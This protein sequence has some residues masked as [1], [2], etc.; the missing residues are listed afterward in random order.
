M[1]ILIEGYP[2]PYETVKDLV[3]LDDVWG[4][5]EKNV[6]MPYVG[7]F[8]NPRL[9]DC[10]F[11]LPKVLL[12]TNDLVFGKY[13]PE[14]II[15]FRE[16]GTFKDSEESK[17]KDE[18]QLIYTL[19]V[20]IYR[21]IVV[22]K[23]D[24]NNDTSIVFEEKV[25]QVG[26][27][28]RKQSDTF[29]DI[30]L[31]LLQFNRDN[32]D[33]FMFILK[34]LHSGFNKIN[35]T[36]TISKSQA[37]VQSKGCCGRQDVSYLNPVN[38]KRTINFDEELLVIFFSI[39]H[40]LHE[41]YGFPVTI[42]ENFD[43]ITGKQFDRYLH[44]M[45][46]R[47]LRQIKYKY[48]SDKA[49]QL[50]EL[51]YAF[52]DQ[53]RQIFVNTDKTEFLLVKNFNIVF[54]AIIDALIGD[55]PLPDGMDK[56]QRDG[57]IVDHLYTAKSLIENQGKT[58]YIG[59]SKY[60]K[61][62]GDVGDTSVYKQYT[63]A[64]NVIQWNLDIFNGKNDKVK[65]SEVKLRDEETEGYN[66]IPNFFI[67]A[68]LD[69]SYRYNVDGICE[70]E[71]TTT[72]HKMYQFENRLFD[73][74]TMLL[75][76]Y[77]VNFLYVLSM[78]GKNNRQEIQ[79]WKGEV[80][81]KFRK[82]IQK[83]LQEDFTFYALQA[84]EGVDTK[85]YIHSHFKEVIGKV[86]APFSN[87]SI[88]SLALDKEST[89]DNEELLAEL[90]K[91]FFVHECSLGENPEPKIAEARATAKGIAGN[92]EKGGVLMVM[93]ENFATKSAV[94]LADGRIAVGIKYS[95][96]SMEI[97]EHLQTIGF[98][99]FHHRNDNDQHLF[100]VKSECKVIG[101]E[102]LGDYYANV[103]TT[104]MYVSV[105]LGE[106]LD[107]SKVKCS[108]KAYIPNTRYDAQYASVESLSKE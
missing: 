81:E 25:A 18:E 79:R 102:E 28:K 16:N 73:R 3:P 83:W 2:Y 24:A 31:A 98:V 42:N 85:E 100:S 33:F 104:E 36:R 38:K 45:G 43:L 6:L 71:K 35:W 67:S 107:A 54:E 51:C 75:F 5:V 86:Y 14:A 78:Y 90:R 23:N 84:H 39:L 94:F 108:K 76:H 40:H 12:D 66:V 10:V 11:V 64:R 53:T 9:A 22:F 80:R 101:K 27:G 92:P 91:S 95:K 99:L 20:W 17:A 89:N 59:D 56:Q 13:A 60:Y 74:D 77:D 57:K 58:Y 30:L 15:N 47:R 52:F 63:Y 106:E 103:K 19:S 72:R 65:T 50:W 8:Y 34:N 88:L 69:K 4:K 32:K 87:H 37:V 49:L 1:R 29:L 21:A 48:Y 55:N 7:Y 26:R 46:V 61:L 105:Q 68:R 41:H 82:T 44:S 70:S 97:V 93:M 62:S 96:D